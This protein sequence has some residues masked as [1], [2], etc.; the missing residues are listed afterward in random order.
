MKKF[1]TV[2]VKHK[3]KAMTKCNTPNTMIL[4]VC[5]SC[6]RVTKDKD[7]ETFQPKKDRFGWVCGEYLPVKG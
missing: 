3:G 6:K 1:E 2:F 4:K 7:A 5:K